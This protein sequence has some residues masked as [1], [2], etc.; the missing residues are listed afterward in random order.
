M[1]DAR[2]SNSV[3]ALIQ[4]RAPSNHPGRRVKSVTNVSRVISPRLHNPKKAVVSNVS[5]YGR[6]VFGQSKVSVVSGRP[7]QR[8]NWRNSTNFGLYNS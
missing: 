4:S 7:G 1:E 6:T 8:V 2:R 3:C 5:H